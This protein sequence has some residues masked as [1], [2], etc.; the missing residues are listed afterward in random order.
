[1][2]AI[3]VLVVEDEILI[4]ETIRLYL[5]E[6]GHIY[7][8]CAISYEEAID[9][10]ERCQPDLVLLDVRLYG[11]K[12]GIDFAHYLSKNDLKTPY[13]F[14]SSQFDKK[15]IKDALQTKPSGYLT[16]P[17]IKETLWTMLELVYSNH[18]QTLREDNATINISDGS[19]IHNINEKD[20]LYISAEHVY[21]KIQLKNGNAIMSRYSLS[22]LLQ[23]LKS[24]FFIQCHRSYIINLN[25]VT[26]WNNSHLFINQENI[27]ISRSRKNEILDY[28]SQKN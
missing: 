17:I 2:N 14:L 1:M 26:S 8:D 18:K 28:F 15:V 3:K 9:A 10:F 27:P 20:I 24:A 22:Q 5:E 6:R 13:I 19:S 12:S 21:I 7:L 25:E 16:K 11:N 23:K 4:A